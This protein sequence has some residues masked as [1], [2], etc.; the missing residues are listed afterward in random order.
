[1]KRYGT[2]ELRRLEVVNLCDGARLGYAGDFEFETDGECARI[3]A[4]VI[5]GSGGFLGFGREDDLVIPWCRVEC[6]GEDAVLV[7]LTPQELGG[8]ACER[9]RGGLF[10]RRK[11]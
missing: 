10:G 4:L 3:T 7:R 5:C 2:A 8:C 1:M 11:C 6:I 9:R